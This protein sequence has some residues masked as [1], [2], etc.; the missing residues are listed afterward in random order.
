MTN[1][2]LVLRLGV[3]SFAVGNVGMAAAQVGSVRQDAAT[4]DYL[5]RIRTTDGALGDVRVPARNRV[6]GEVVV[7]ISLSAEGR[8]R[9]GYSLRVRQASPQALLTFVVPCSSAADIRD[10]AGV[11][12]TAESG[13]RPLLVDK[14]EVECEALTRLAPN[15]SAV[16]SFASAWLPSLTRAQLIG[17]AAM[18]EWP[19]ECW[20]DPANE[21]AM[22]AIDT[23][24]GT[25][26][27]GAT[28]LVLAPLRSPV[29]VATPAATILHLQSDLWLLCTP[30]G[31]LTAPGICRSLETKLEA[32]GDA[33]ARENVSA[34]KGAAGALA[35]E[36]HAQRGKQVPELAFAL[37][38]FYVQ[39]LAQQL[40]P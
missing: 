17:S 2:M 37:L 16:M 6:L 34:A 30:M 11:E 10:L 38:S 21:P 7:S 22:A 26:G 12:F 39:R 32:V 25:H 23:L 18:P 31:I 20:G 14:G 33:V 28:A 24:D 5:V 8:P 3:L 36:L 29:R 40:G 15:D 9:Y 1:L 27:G 13:E 4:G 35:H 19:C